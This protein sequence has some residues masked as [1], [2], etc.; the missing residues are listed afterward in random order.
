MVE[1]GLLDAAVWLGAQ[2]NGC[3]TYGLLRLRRKHKGRDDAVVAL[4][5]AGHACLVMP[6]HATFPVISNQAM[7]SPSNRLLVSSLRILSISDL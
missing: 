1:N 3:L 6:A 5:K 4:L 7:L 2:S